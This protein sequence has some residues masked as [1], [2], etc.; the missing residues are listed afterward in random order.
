MEEI[1]P[2]MYDSLFILARCSLNSDAF[3]EEAVQE[4]FVIACHKSE[5]LFSSGSPEGW[6]VNT[7]KNVICNMLCRQAFTQR[8]LRLYLS[9]RVHESA[10]NEDQIGFDFLCRAVVHQC[11]FQRDRHPVLGDDRFSSRH[12][13]R[14]HR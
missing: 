10:L 14:I 5:A 6:L 4:T 12:S 2:Q 1:Y 7:L 11:L 8:Q 13:G 9:G 3:A